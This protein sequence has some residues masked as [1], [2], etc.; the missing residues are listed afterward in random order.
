MYGLLSRVARVATERA[1][2]ILPSCRCVCS[3]VT[4]CGRGARVHRSL[5]RSSP[6]LPN[7][8]VACFPFFSVLV[9]FGVRF[10]FFFNFFIIFLFFLFFVSVFLFLF[11]FFFLWSL[12]ET[13]RGTSLVHDL[14]F[15]FQP[16]S[17]TLTIAQWG[18]CCPLT[19]S[20]E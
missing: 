16:A 14:G 19:P 17:P 9:S 5:G 12:L 20:Q 8:Q 1:L 3:H 6:S 13:T 10:F 7:Q 18:D 2:A 15:F 11:L 4:G